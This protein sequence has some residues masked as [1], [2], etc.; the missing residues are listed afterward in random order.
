[1]AEKRAER[2]VADAAKATRVELL[3]AASSALVVAHCGLRRL[4]ACKSDVLTD[5]LLPIDAALH[6]VGAALDELLD[7]D[8]DA[9]QQG[10][11]PY[12]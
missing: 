4:F 8:L 7:G 6:E 1:M 2:I 9:V 10:D 11:R 3:C 12:I 5:W